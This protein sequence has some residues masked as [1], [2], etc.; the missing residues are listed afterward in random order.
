MLGLI[1]QT[2][3][4]QWHACA[5]TENECIEI[6]HARFALGD[7]PIGDLRAGRGENLHLE[8]EAGFEGRLEFLP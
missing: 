6:A 5:G 3:F 1:E 8:A 7:D 4:N 2:G